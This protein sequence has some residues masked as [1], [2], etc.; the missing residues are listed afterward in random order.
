MKAT[1]ARSSKIKIKRK[2]FDSHAYSS[3]SVVR[4]RETE[5]DSSFMIFSVP[6]FS[7]ASF[8]AHGIYQRLAATGGEEAEELGRIT[9]LLQE[10]IHDISN[11]LKEAAEIAAIS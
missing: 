8:L 5:P 7:L 11:G 10:T 3:L 9:K 6:K 4:K 1:A 2:W